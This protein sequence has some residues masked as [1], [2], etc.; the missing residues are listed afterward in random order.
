MPPNGS[1]IPDAELAVLKKWV[2]DGAGFDGRN[3]TAQLTSL[4]PGG[5]QAAAAPVV[6]QATGNETVSFAK[7]IAPVLAQNCTGCHGTDN[8]RA[9]FSL[10][11][12]ARLMAGNSDNGP[13]VCPVGSGQPDYSKLKGT[14]KQ[15]VRMPMGRSRS[16][17]A[18][19]AKV[20]NGSTKAQSS[21]APTR[22]SPW[23]KLPPLPRLREPRTSSSRPTGSSRPRRTGGWECPS[24][25][26]QKRNR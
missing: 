14:A 19:I 25:V 17:S 12:M 26:M 11:T 7:D 23:R 22:I 2:E 5:A 4:I 8:P 15:G 1:G 16:T 6:Q 18:I 24:A 13:V 10:N 9:N 20:E 21:T 3:P